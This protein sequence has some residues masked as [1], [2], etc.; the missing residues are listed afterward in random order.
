MVQCRKSAVNLLNV[1]VISLLYVLSILVIASPA[2]AADANIVNSKDWRDVYSV[3]LYSSLQKQ[4]AF[5]VTSESLASVTKIFPTDPEFTIYQSTDPYI[6]N[7][8]NQLASM[9]YKIKNEEKSSSFNTELDPKT[10]NYIIISADNYKLSVSVAPYAV[11]TNSWVFIVDDKNVDDV[12]SQLSGAANVLAVGTFP[13]AVL[14]KIQPYFKEWINTN[15]PYHDSQKIA[16]KFGETLPSIVVADGSALEMEFFS[17]KNPVLLTGANKI[18]DDTFDFFVEKNTKSIVVIG[19]QLAVVGEQIRER[20]DKKIGVFIKFGQSSVSTV[21]QIYALSFFP[22]PQPTMKLDITK[23]VYNPLSKQII[24]Y[25]ENMG[26]SGLYFLSNFVVLDEND[27][28]LGTGSDSTPVFLGAGEALS[29]TYDSQLPIEQLSDKTRA[30]FFTS[31]GFYPAALDSFLTNDKSYG[32]PFTISLEV[33]EIAE[34]SVQLEVLDATYYTGLKRVGVQLSNPGTQKVYYSLKVNR[35]IVNGLEQDL[36]KKDFLEPGKTKTTYLQ[37]ALDKV[38]LEEN[39]VFHINIAYGADE[40]NMFKRISL[41][42]EFKYEA[43]SFI[44]GLATS[45]GGTGSIVGV[46]VIIV[47]ALAIYFFVKKRKE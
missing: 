17:T 32:T 21:G 20:S 26:N 45:I 35:V 38:D 8:K 16:E 4:P 11:K 3:L 46:I 15:D 29:V 43:G 25:Y 7:L 24:V 19:N 37:A 27:A 6:S 40:S 18:L 22:L 9:N 31:Y 42:K 14:A 34:S 44:T 10:G 5:F 47:I 28:E 13:R 39:T 36:F 33:Q 41:D 30:N 23:L 2:H 12:A 1:S